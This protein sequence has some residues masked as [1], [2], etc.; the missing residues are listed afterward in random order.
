MDIPAGA[1]SHQVIDG[2]E[3]RNKTKFTVSYK[4]PSSKL[5]P[6]KHQ[7]SRGTRNITVAMETKDKF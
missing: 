3:E 2:S 5:M 6:R 4:E 7:C 1:M